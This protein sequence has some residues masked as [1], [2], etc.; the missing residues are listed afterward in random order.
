MLLYSDPE[1]IQSDADTNKKLKMESWKLNP[2][3]LHTNE[4]I[5]SPVNCLFYFFPL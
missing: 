2:A 5:I 3:K 4:I 1:N